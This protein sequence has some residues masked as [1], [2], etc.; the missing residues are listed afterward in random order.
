MGANVWHFIAV[1]VLIICSSGD[2]S[3]NSSDVEKF[4]LC[5]NDSAICSPGLCTSGKALLSVFCCISFML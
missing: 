2:S 1:I 3:S 5:V 4:P